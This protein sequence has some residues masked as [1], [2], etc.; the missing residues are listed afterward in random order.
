MKK[1]ASIGTSSKL[2][3][4]DGRVE[5][6]GDLR[7]P[8]PA[9]CTPVARRSTPS[10]RDTACSR[11]VVSTWKATSKRPAAASSVRRSRVAR[12][13]VGQKRGAQAA[14]GYAADDRDELVAAAHSRVAA[15]DLDA[16]SRTVGRADRVDPPEENL[17]REIPH[18]FG[19]F[20]EIAESAV[21]VAALRDF[22]RHAADRRSSAQ[23]LVAESGTS[24]R[25]SPRFG[26]AAARVPA[27]SSYTGRRF[28]ES[29][30]SIIA[31]LLSPV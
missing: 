6:H 24:G 17:D 18:R 1:R 16:D 30:E 15:R 23:D 7:G 14:L 25:A 5:D 11:C 28:E 12:D 10:R 22:E 26:Q 13:A 9:R 2:P 8:E 27:R 31:A 29:N 4:M 19:A 20:G 3:G 21:E